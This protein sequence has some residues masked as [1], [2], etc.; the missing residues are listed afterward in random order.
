MSS[1][2]LCCIPHLQ[3]ILQMLI[4]RSCPQVWLLIAMSMV[5]ISCFTM[6]LVWAEG[7]V[8]NRR[9]NDANAHTVLWVIKSVTQESKSTM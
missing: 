5:A 3:T 1:V 4:C 8:Y 2:T 7:H 6:L 9:V